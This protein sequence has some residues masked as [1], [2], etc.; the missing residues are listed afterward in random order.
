MGRGIFLL[1]AATPPLPRWRSTVGKTLKS[2]VSPKSQTK[3][4]NPS[5]WDLFFSMLLWM[6]LFSPFLLGDIFKFYQRDVVWDTCVCTP[7]YFNEEQNSHCVVL[8]N[9]LD[10]MVNNCLSWYSKKKKK[11]SLSSFHISR[12][13]ARKQIN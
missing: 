6:Y 5:F 4:N 12:R 11:G 2:D 9:F 10:S 8:W 13:C 3:S 7:K 1:E